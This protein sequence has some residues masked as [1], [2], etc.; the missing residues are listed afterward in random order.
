MSNV[1]KIHIT[2]KT[3]SVC[4]LTAIL[5]GSFAPNIFAMTAEEETELG[6]NLE[7]SLIRSPVNNSVDA[8]VGPVDLQLQLLADVSGSVNGTEFD[9]QR[10]GYVAAFQN[11]VVHTNI[12]NYP[13]CIA[14][15][16][17]YWSGDAQQSIAVPWTQLCNATDSNAFAASIAG[18]VR[19][20]GGQTAPGSAINFGYPLF[21]IT[22]TG[23]KKVIDVSGDGE[24]NDGDDTSDARD[25]A[26]VAGINQI[27]GITIG[28]EDNVLTFYPANI[29]A[30]VGSFVDNSDFVGFEPSIIAK[31]LKETNPPCEVDCNP[32]VGG[33][34][35]NIN[36]TSLFVTGFLS[37][38]LWIAPVAV[39]IAGTGLYLARSKIK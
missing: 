12:G 23:G 34:S 36:M 5:F 3:L 13:N 26:L 28:N 38:A 11:G 7:V 6:R 37:N 22:F 33:E 18:V 9:Q 25:A 32:T 30:G 8:F 15:Q 10:D 16:L 17:I 21:D 2:T 14:V 39:G 35:L 27:N 1:F 29:Q 24:Q 4:A 31:I 20:F 19:P